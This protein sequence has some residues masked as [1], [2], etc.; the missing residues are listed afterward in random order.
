MWQSKRITICVA[1]RWMGEKG[2]AGEVWCM[3]TEEP[4]D[5]IWNRCV[6]VFDR[7]LDFVFSFVFLQNTFNGMK[8]NILSAS[9]ATHSDTNNGRADSCS[10][11]SS[12]C[13][14]C[15]S[16]CTHSFQLQT[17]IIYFFSCIRPFSRY[18]FA[19]KCLQ[20]Q[21]MV[22]ERSTGAIEQLTY[23]NTPTTHYVES[24]DE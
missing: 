15:S 7:V 19:H 24:R 11:T 21:N 14:S 17:M 12:R 9:D 18:N 22:F 23:T 16:S 3:H 8:R 13:T 1:E 2:R 5:E 10:S 4:S 6:C 20:W